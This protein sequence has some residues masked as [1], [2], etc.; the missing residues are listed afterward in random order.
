MDKIATCAMLKAWC[1]CFA[2]SYVLQ[3]V[4]TAVS[5]RTVLDPAKSL[6]SCPV[7]CLLVSKQTKC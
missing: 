2:A 3:Y 7:G 5:G 1:N 6:G 4:N